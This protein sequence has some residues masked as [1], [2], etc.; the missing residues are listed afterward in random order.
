MTKPFVIWLCLF[1]GCLSA[2]VA[3]PSVTPVPSAT[4]SNVAPTQPSPTPVVIENQ[5]WVC[6]NEYDAGTSALRGTF[7]PKGCYSSSCTRPL[8]QKV[9]VALDGNRSEIRFRTHFTLLDTTVREPEPRSCTAD[10]DGGGRIPFEVS[11]VKAQ[12]YS[13]WIGDRN[14]GTIQ[15]TTSLSITN[16]ICLGESD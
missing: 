12:S 15:V 10:C 11:D 9:D 3:T 6:F 5:G 14:F 13:V 4:V 2:C 16:A 7:R 1:A 8:E